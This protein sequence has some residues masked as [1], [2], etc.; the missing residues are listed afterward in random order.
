MI[1]DPKCQGRL[2]RYVLYILVVPASVILTSFSL[3]QV[4]SSQII[5]PENVALKRDNHTV[6][7]LI[8]N[9]ASEDMTRT[10]IYILLNQSLVNE[11]HLLT[12]LTNN[13]TESDYDPPAYDSLSSRNSHLNSISSSPDLEPSRLPG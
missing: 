10:L 4:R 3:V 1:M 9:G 5:S 8:A 6:H 2:V 13:S 11:T 12:D 7:Y